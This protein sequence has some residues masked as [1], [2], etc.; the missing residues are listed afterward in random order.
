MIN[1]KFLSELLQLVR[2]VSA[3]LV[4]ASGLILA[5]C[6]SREADL[7]KGPETDFKVEVPTD[8]P[9]TATAPGTPPANGT[10]PTDA[11]VDGADVALPMTVEANVL[12][13]AASR[14]AV[15]AE[16][17]EILGAEARAWPDGCLGLGGPDD[18]C[19]FAVVDGWQ[20]TV[21]QS[22]DPSSQ[23]VYRTDADGLVVK[24]ADGAENL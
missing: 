1:T 10:M 13:D 24:A 3:V 6:N 7:P 21:G 22:G 12:Q 18:I 16:D 14:Y 15:P 2:V 17:L 19:T 23:W 4:L 11:P 9:P 5:G 8:V 20:V